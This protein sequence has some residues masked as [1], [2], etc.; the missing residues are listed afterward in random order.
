MMR[1][2]FHRMLATLPVLL[3]LSIGVFSML[4]LA[5][6]DPVTTMLSDDLASPQ[7]AAALRHQLGLDRPLYVQYGWWLRRALHGDLGYSYR[8]KSRVASEITARLPVTIE[9]TVFAIAG[10]LSIAVPLGVI[11][12]LRRN[13]GLDALISGIGAL[14]LAMP[15]FW[16]G[17]LLILLFAVRL[18]WLPPSGYAPPWRGLGP[19]LRLM[20]LPVITLGMSYVSVVMRIARMSVLDVIKAD[21]IKTARAKGIQESRVVARHVLRSALIPIITVVALETGRLLGGAV[22]TETIF[23]L[24]GIGRLAVD[25]V[26]DRD[27]PVLQAVTLFMALALIAANL[28]ADVLYAWADPR[29]RYG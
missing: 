12:A 25:S 1:F 4:H 6:G 19:N 13:T 24:P 8:S 26:L 28:L 21:Y 23:A 22:V 29:I 15:A 20:I 17:V 18:H 16:L 9:L 3:F 27:F 5:P 10:A 2:L 11:A 7:V 14:G